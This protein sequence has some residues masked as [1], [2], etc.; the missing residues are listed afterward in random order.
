MQKIEGEYKV[1]GVVDGSVNERKEQ[2]YEK[3]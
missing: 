2:D 1:F 3:E